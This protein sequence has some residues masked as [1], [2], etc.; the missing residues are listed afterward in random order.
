MQ[1][2]IKHFSLEKGLEYIVTFNIKCVF[3]ID[4][5]LFFEQVRSF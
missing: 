4:S 3:S 1:I 5:Y 2:T